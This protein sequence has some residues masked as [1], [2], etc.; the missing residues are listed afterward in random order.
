MHSLLIKNNE[1]MTFQF[2]KVLSNK[3]T[4]IFYLSMLLQC[5]V[6]QIFKIAVL[7]FI[8]NKQSV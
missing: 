7:E 8:R 6:V 5:H 1:F 2:M 4:N 3:K